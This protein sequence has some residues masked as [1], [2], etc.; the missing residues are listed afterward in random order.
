MFNRTIQ[1]FVVTSELAKGRVKSSAEQNSADVSAESGKNG[2]ATVFRLTVISAA[3]LGA[4][5]S[6]A[7]TAGRGLIA[8][9]PPTSATAVSGATATGIGALS[10]GASA[11]ATANGAVAVGTSA[12]ATHNNSLAVGTNA[13]ATQNHA[14][15]MGADTS[16]S[17]SHATAIGKSANAV[18]AD[19]TALGADSKANGTQ[20]TAVGKNALADNTSTTAL[21]NS[22]QAFGIGSMALGQSS[23]SRGQNGIA[24]GSGSQA[25]ANAQ[26]AIAIDNNAVGYQSESIAIGNSAQ[27]Q[28]GNTIA[29]GKDAVANSPGSGSAP[30]SAI[31]LGADANATGLG[32]IAIGRASG[33]LSQ[34]IMNVN[35]THNNIAIGNTARVGD[36]SSSK[37]TQSIAIGSGNRVDPQGRPEGA[38]AKGDQSI[39][40]GGNVLANGNSSVA[41]GGDDLDA[42]GGTRYS[43]NATD[44]FIKYNAQGA[45][46]GEYTLSGKSLRDIYKEMTGDTMNY[47]SYGN[48]IA[49]QGSVAL[50]VQSNS[51]ADLSLAIDAVSG[52]CLWRCSFGYRCKSNSAELCGFGYGF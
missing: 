51:S 9:D 4:G 35:V 50:G 11:N 2:I 27:A 1:S 30:S 34:N 26:N 21:G 5:N 29:I 25:A 8:V 10:V 40:V 39:A 24:I 44:K 49:G 18:S 45:K 22:A 15:A 33:V 23:T 48:T 52:H 6:Y 20:A 37:I 3:L 16:A 38:W 36:S 28:T 12:N 13:K 32:T 19:S 17:S 7:A 46:T 41:I 47:G 43:G 14:V 31:A 42:V